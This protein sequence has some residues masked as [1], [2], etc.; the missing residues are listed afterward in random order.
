MR[1]CLSV[2]QDEAREFLKDKDVDFSRYIYNVLGAGAGDE[3]AFYEAKNAAKAEAGADTA[4][5]PPTA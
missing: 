4:A 3:F 2:P 1:F 5:A